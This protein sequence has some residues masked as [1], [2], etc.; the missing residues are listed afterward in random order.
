[1]NQKKGIGIILLIIGIVAF[2]FAVYEKGRVARAKS[3]ISKGSE[4]FSNNAFGGAIGE[5]LESKASQYD[6][7]L[8]LIE[9]GGIILAV[10]G[11]GMLLFCK[12]KKK[13]K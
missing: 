4:L 1:M 3:A 2:W 11:G 13:R 8:T 6:T 5:T 9:I 12:G 7:P 10:V